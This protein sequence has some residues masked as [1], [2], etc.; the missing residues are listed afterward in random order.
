MRLMIEY[1]PLIVGLIYAS[2][3]DRGDLI[4]E[5]VLLRQQPSVLTRPTRRRPRLRTRD[6]L[7]WLVARALRRDWC[8]HL[9]LVT[10]DTVVS[11]HRRGWR[12]L[13][14]WRSRGGPG[15]PRLSAEVRDLIARIAQDN[16]SWGAERI[17]GELLKLGIAVSKRSIQHRRRRGPVQPPHQSWRTF[18][19]NHRASAWA[20]D[21]LTVQTVT[22]RTL[23]VLLFG[24][25]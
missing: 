24:S 17:R 16:P 21:L 9:V 12:L 8:R 7:F 3:R 15:R 25:H 2:L 23:C 22:F 6:R 19:H 14:R 11:W 4:A 20:A 1:S 5:N 18:L 13:W 10:P